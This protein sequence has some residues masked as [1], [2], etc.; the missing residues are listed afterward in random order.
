MATRTDEA[1]ILRVNQDLPVAFEPSLAWPVF[2]NGLRGHL[3]VNVPMAANL[4]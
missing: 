4:I 2:Q 1:S 3:T